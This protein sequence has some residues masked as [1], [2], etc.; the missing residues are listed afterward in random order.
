[1]I[2]TIVAMHHQR[3]QGLTLLRGIYGGL[4]THGATALT[5]VAAGVLLRAG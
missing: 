4:P 3:N 2:R 5:M 1:M